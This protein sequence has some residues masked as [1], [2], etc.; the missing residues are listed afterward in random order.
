[1]KNKSLKSKVMFV[2]ILMHYELTWSNNEQ[3]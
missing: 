2:N 3:L 1:M